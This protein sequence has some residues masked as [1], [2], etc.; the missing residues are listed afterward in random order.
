MKAYTLFDVNSSNAVIANL[1]KY[2]SYG[3]SPYFGKYL[4]LL[5][6]GKYSTGA[7]SGKSSHH[8]RSRTS[9]SSSP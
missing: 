6:V 8:I 9:V 5:G 3:L 4:T 1:E 7:I 2:A